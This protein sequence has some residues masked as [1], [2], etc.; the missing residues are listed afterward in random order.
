M[1]YDNCA[2]YQV[3]LEKH[4]VLIILYISGFETSIL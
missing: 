3:E 4:K 2:L 1:R